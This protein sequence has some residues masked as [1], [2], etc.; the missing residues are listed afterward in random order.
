MQR[1]SQ[2]NE[3]RTI[4]CVCVCSTRWQLNR[5]RLTTILLYD[6]TH[7][8]LGYAVRNGT[9]KM[10]LG[11]HKFLDESKLEIISLRAR[12]FLR[13]MSQSGAVRWAPILCVL[14]QSFVG[15]CLASKSMMPT[16]IT[17]TCVRYVLARVPAWTLNTRR[18]FCWRDDAGKLNTGFACSFFRYSLSTRRNDRY[19][20]AATSAAAAAAAIDCVC[21]L[22]TKFNFSRTSPGARHQASPTS[23][24]EFAYKFVA[25]FCVLLQA[26]N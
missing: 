6:S 12:S 10:S 24:T 20:Y 22:I 17:A 26:L 5:L 7:I 15:F 4:E 2:R 25:I 19:N 14:V 16:M 13:W 21:I 23:A 3:E 18:L 9:G 11:C 1:V 8:I